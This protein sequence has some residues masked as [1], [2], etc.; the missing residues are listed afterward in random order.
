M[1]NAHI[2]MN[3]TEV[4]RFATT[5]L[6]QAVE[7][8]L[9]EADKSIDDVDYIVCHQANER[10][11]RHVQ[12]KY[13]GSEDRFFINIDKYGNTS[14]ASIPIAL[15]EMM[16]QKLLKQGMKVLCVGFGAGLTWSGALIE[17]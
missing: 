6:A 10:I 17:I 16:E 7:E 15:D 12:K 14:A 1:D 3:G 9:K 11:I 4:F 13:P 8:T 2:L 5:A